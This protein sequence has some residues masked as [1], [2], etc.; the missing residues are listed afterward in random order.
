VRGVPLIVFHGD[1]DPIVGHVNADRLVA[2]ALRSFRAG[3][4]GSAEQGR[5]PD[6]H[7][8]TRSIYKDAN[9]ETLVEQW[10][11]HEAGHAWSGGSPRGSYTDPRG[12][13]ASAELIRF[14][15]EHPHQVP[16]S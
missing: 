12:P 2:D 14:F 7:A 16:G 13:D 5:V 6:G 11:I 1:K 3:A 9:G 4:A 15:R 10:R 8:Y